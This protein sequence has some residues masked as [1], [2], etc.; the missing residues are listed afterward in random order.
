MALRTTDDEPRLLYKIARAYY[1]D[2]ATQERIARRFGLSRP[3]VSRLLRQARDSGVVHISIR[4]PGPGCPDLERE[5]EARFDLDEAVLA[6]RDRAPVIE[7]IGAAAAA[8]FARTVQPGDTV[9]L[10]WGTSLREFAARLPHL[11]L[12]RVTV[13][14]LIGGLGSLDA[15]VNGAELTRRVAERCGARPRILQA[16]GVV[17]TPA[18][19][20]ALL[21]DRE[22][23][24]SLEL[25]RMATVAWMGLG[26]PRAASA[27]FGP[28]GL[29]SHR[30]LEA[31][32][33]RGAVADVCLR[34]F[35]AG[36]RPVE[37]GFERRVLGI[38]LPDLLAIRRR[39]AVAGGPE[40][41]PAIRGALAGK[42]VNVL[43][44][45]EDTA[46]ALLEG[47]EG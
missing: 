22:V 5:L 31:I 34:Y 45:D 11:E 47:A 37:T 25:G 8:Y 19:K 9:G 14:Q 2:G 26:V 43:V 40:K 32:R 21:S 23:A 6:P 4:R 28:E 42:L 41:V 36:G 13:V 7:R 17:A 18:V 29:L 24:R 44:S 39:V 1:Q 20:A 12:P 3:K 15:G 46:R 16:P 27:L 30:D 10:S 38:E 35:D 33:A